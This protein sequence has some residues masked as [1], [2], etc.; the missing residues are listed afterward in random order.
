MALPAIPDELLVEILL[1][2]PTAADLIRASA[3]CVSFRRLIA[4][5][6]FTRRFRK[7]HPPPL[8]GFLDTGRLRFHPAVP[9]HPSAPAA[10]AVASAADFSFDFLPSPCSSRPWS[11]QDV[12]DG[13]VLL[14][15]PRP[16]RR[17]SPSNEMVVC[18]PLHR[19]Y[20]LLPRIPDDLAAS[21][22]HAQGFCYEDSC[23][24][25]SGDH[26]EAAAT[27][28]ASFRVIWMMLLPTKPVIF[29]F[30][31]GT[32]QWRTVPSLT[33]S[34]MSPGFV[35][36][37]H[38]FSFL[39]RHY[40]H[41]C[42]YWT[43]CSTEKFLALDI[44]RME[45]SVAVHPPCERKPGENVVIAEADQGMILMFVPKPNTSPV[46]YTVWRNNGGRFTQWQMEKPITLDSGSGL[47]GAAGRHLLLY[48]CGTSSVG[49]SCFTRDV[50]TFQLERVCSAYPKQTHAYCNFPPSLLS[51]PTVSIGTHHADI[52]GAG[53]DVPV[54]Q[55]R[56]S[57][58]GGVQRLVA[59][60]ATRA[61]NPCFATE[62]TH[63]A[64][65]QGAGDDVPVPQ[66]RGS[67]C[68]GVEGPVFP[69]AARASN[70]LFVVEA[71]PHADVRRQ[72][73]DDVRVPELREA[74]PEDVT[75]CNAGTR[76]VCA[77][78]QGAGDDVLVPKLQEAD[79]GGVQGPV[80]A[81]AAQAPTPSFVVEGTPHADIWEVEDVVPVPE[82]REA[83][84]G[85]VQGPVLASAAQAPKPSFDNNGAEA[86]RGGAR[87]WRW[88]WGWTC[89]VC[90][91]QVAEVRGDE[92]PE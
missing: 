53:D 68:G 20:L 75:L 7:L 70:P 83:G 54:P 56:E 78:A 65:I 58:P 60:A 62:G 26:E 3:A 32:G 80:V 69:A 79:P 57:D 74:G 37:T 51:S 45:F 73:G 48:Y 15:R 14:E 22:V 63:H 44:R 55:L 33:W 13:R 27:D 31:S 19:H 81:A 42:F 88:G 4:D 71:A 84:P 91:G 2:L 61:P 28:E 34:E 59:P 52:Q 89:G 66:V 24:V 46:I 49:R 8:L 21:V 38:V 18:D 25:P 29:V 41:G 92:G 77:D 67:D 1:R 50:N 90:R 40:A 30:C 76:H 82:A 36:S 87:R 10:R 11:V 23:L 47:M 64:D 43:S 85:G 17:E 86:G 5:R 9:P 72:A 39:R 35:L 6:S 16:R 12:L